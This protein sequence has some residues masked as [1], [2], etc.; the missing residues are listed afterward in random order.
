MTI[1]ATYTQA[2]ANLAKYLND[3]TENREII[4]IERK[5]KGSNRSGGAVETCGWR[6]KNAFAGRSR[7]STCVDKET[8][9]STQVD[10]RPQAPK[11]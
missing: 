5:K 1:T 11:P 9:A 3:V 2:R 8:F 7:L 4:L 6:K 10:A